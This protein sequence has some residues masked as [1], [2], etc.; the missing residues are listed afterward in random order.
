MV[1]HVRSSEWIRLSV[2]LRGEAIQD[3]LRLVVYFGSKS[4]TRSWDASRDRKPDKAA[5]NSWT[6]QRAAQPIRIGP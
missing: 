5:G 3:G 4:R 1:V 6:Q 2:W